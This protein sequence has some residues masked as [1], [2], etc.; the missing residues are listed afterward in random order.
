MIF[1]LSDN[2]RVGFI[3]LL[4]LVGVMLSSSC[5]SSR[6]NPLLGDRDSSLRCP[7][8]GCVD[9]A[10]SSDSVYIQRDQNKSTFLGAGDSSVEISG[11]CSAST[12]PDNRI[13]ITMAGNP[14]SFYAIN[15]GSTAQIPKCSMGKFHLFVDACKFQA[16]S[17]Y[18]LLV[19]LKPIDANQGAVDVD[20][21]FTVSFNRT[22]AAST[23][24]CP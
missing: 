17:G 16:L 3:L 7:S 15:M 4:L 2:L 8:T 22:A 9:T 20:A 21:S 24:V 13:E 10:P 18:N 12:F 1:Q 5:S 19:S 23:S 14:V 6:D 11:T